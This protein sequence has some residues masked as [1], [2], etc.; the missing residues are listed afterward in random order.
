MPLSSIH[1]SVANSRLEKLPQ[2][3]MQNGIIQE[4]EEGQRQRH[5]NINYH[6]STTI[7]NSFNIHN[8]TMEDCYNNI[9]VT[10]SSFSLSASVPIYIDYR[11]TT[12]RNIDGLSSRCIVLRSSRLG[13]FLHT[14]DMVSVR[15]LLLADFRD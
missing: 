15:R 4:T 2:T 12:I 14:S 9:P 5:D 13:G 1:R 7:V 6:C 3:M 8:I 11:H 10:R